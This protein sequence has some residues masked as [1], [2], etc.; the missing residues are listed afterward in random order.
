M[1]KVLPLKISHFK[2]QQKQNNLNT[3][4]ISLYLRSPVFSHVVR[5]IF[6]TGQL[7]EPE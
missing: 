4:Q 2:F 5:E 7:S 6:G 1:N 3:Y